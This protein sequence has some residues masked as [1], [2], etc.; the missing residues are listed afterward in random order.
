MRTMVYKRYKCFQDQWQF[1]DQSQFK[2]GVSHPDVRPLLDSV[3]K[4]WFQTTLINGQTIK[5]RKRPS[6]RPSGVCGQE[7][8]VICGPIFTKFG[9]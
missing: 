8:D 3:D 6:V 1:I 2:S 5:S 7:C 9:A 4:D